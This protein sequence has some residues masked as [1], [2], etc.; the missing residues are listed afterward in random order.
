MKRNT[1][2]LALL[3]FPDSAPPPSPAAARIARK[4]DE[5]PPSQA[6]ELESLADELLER[7]HNRKVAL[8]AVRQRIM[9]LCA[10]TTSHERRQFIGEV[11]EDLLGRLPMP[12]HDPAPCGPSAGVSVVGGRQ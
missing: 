10:G 9:T 6:T 3:K 8:E 12:E 4:I 5:L 11:V 7:Q 1:Q 2:H